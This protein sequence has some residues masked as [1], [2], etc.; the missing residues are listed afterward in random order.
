MAGNSACGRPSHGEQHYHSGYTNKDGLYEV[1]VDSEKA[2]LV[3]VTSSIF[4]APFHQLMIK[5]G[6]Q[7]KELNFQLSD[8]T[9]VYGKLTTEN[10]TIKANQLMVNI[11]KQVT[12]YDGVDKIGNNSKR[13]LPFYRFGFP[14]NQGNYKIHVPAGAYKINIWWLENTKPLTIK[15]GEQKEVNFHVPQQ[16]PLHKSQN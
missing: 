10:K 3:S 15:Q 9:Y 7:D 14:D 5:E 2:Y 11:S 4:S 8:D 6:S 13:E 16:S 12:L 1:M